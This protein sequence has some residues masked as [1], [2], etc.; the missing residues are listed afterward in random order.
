MTYE[1]A[2][3]DRSNDASE[4][5]QSPSA[6][7]VLSCEKL[8]QASSQSGAYCDRGSGVNL[9]HIIDKPQ[10]LTKWRSKK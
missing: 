8:L 10:V 9:K 7:I 2:R 5:A 1:F 4:C 6:E 3:S